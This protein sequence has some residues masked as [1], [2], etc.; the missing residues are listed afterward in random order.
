MDRQVEWIVRRGVLAA[1]LYFAM[2]GGVAWL[3]Y[4][5]AAFAW[6]TLATSVWALPVGASRS[7]VATLPN[8]NAMIFDLAVLGAM[9]V[10]HW[11]WTAF[12]YAA[13]CGCAALAQ[14]RATGKL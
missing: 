2:V 7:R 5:V 11:Y 12:A 9:F 8:F 6:W 4:A 14:A 10:A 1:A 3:G 13:S